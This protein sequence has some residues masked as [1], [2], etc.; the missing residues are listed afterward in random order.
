MTTMT[1]VKKENTTNGLESNNPD[2][3]PNQI[4]LHRQ[5]L[6]ESD[7]HINNNELSEA[8]HNLLHSEAPLY[9]FV[10]TGGTYLNS[11]TYPM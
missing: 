9:K 1:R 2:A 5:D 11:E 6:P 7:R 8:E 4:D 10:L 3:H